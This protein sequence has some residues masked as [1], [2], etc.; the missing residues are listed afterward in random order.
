MNGVLEHF[1]PIHLDISKEQNNKTNSKILERNHKLHPLFH[2]QLSFCFPV[3]THYFAVLCHCFTV[4]LFSNISSICHFV[5]IAI[6]S[7]DDKLHTWWKEADF[8]F[9]KKIKDDLVSVCEPQNQV[10]V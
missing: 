10:P 8:G 7:V 9:V 2:F 5:I 4:L 3:S 6:L 1:L